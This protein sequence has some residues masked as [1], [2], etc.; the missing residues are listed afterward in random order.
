MARR[1]PTPDVFGGRAGSAISTQKL[2]GATFLVSVAA[3]T[4][5]TTQGG[6]GDHHLPSPRRYGAIVLAWF[7]FGLAAELG[8]QVARF[9]GALAALVTLT[10]LMGTAGKR[11]IAWLGGTAASLSSAG[12]SRAE[13]EQAQA[14]AGLGGPLVGGGAPGTGAGRRTRPGAGGGGGGFG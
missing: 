12:P 14:A 2:L 7:L 9:T 6:D 4:I 5:G 13:R 10:M 3:A 8:G 1:L 11:A